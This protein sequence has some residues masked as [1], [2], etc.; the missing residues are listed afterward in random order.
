ML[1]K[2]SERNKAPAAACAGVTIE[3]VEEPSALAEQIAALDATAGAWTEAN[4]PEMRTDADI[5]RWLDEL[6][7]L[8]GESGGRF[9]DHRDAS[10]EA[11]RNG[12]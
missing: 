2:R 3:G 9:W 5:D 11:H 8:W 1:P 10:L 4:H 12:L 7:G 6:R